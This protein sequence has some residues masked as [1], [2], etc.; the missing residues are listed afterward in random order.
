MPLPQ[1]D[2]GL[3]VI[4]CGVIQVPDPPRIFPTFTTNIYKV[5]EN[6]HILCVGSRIHHHAIATTLFG[7]YLGVWQKT[8]VHTWATSDS[9]VEWLRLQSHMECFQSLLQLG[10]VCQYEDTHVAIM[11]QNTPVYP[12]CVF[13]L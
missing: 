1:L 6:I 5:F 9:I 7:P 4:N 12:L 2:P 3:Q 8:W 10:L 13:H 11:D